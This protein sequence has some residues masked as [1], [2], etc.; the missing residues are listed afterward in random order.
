MWGSEGGGP[1]G[2]EGG[3]RYAASLIACHADVLKKGTG[4][5]PRAFHISSATSGFDTARAVGSRVSGRLHSW[6]CH[7]D[8]RTSK[9]VQYCSDAITSSVHQIE[10]ILA[11]RRKISIWAIH[12]DDRRGWWR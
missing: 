2:A 1:G 6:T 3:L 8:Q 10:D 9:R 12:G 7:G 5:N 11:R 4:G